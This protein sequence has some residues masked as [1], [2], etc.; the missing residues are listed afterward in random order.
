MVK[1]EPA[2]VRRLQLFTAAVEVC[3]EKGYAATRVDDIA[4]EAGLSK[5]A[6]YHHFKS[7]QDLF[8]QLFEDMIVEMERETLQALEAMDSAVDAFRLLNATYAEL[9]EVHPNMI[10]GMLDYYM[11][12]YRD[13]EVREM[14]IGLYDRPTSAICKMIQH[15]QDQG[16]FDDSYDA[17]ELTWTWL[18]AGDGLVFLHSYSHQEDLAVPPM[19]TLTAT[20]LRGIPPNR[21][22][23][24]TS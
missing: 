22:K 2:D 13:D 17:N 9:V 21:S 6:L 14:F 16:E 20:S 8:T 10:R 4:A 11:S 5:G 7:K 18:T 23:E 12:N 1:H 15:G 24:A 19:N 3:A